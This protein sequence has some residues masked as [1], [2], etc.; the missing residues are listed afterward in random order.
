M[1]NYNLIRFYT[2]HIV[3]GPNFD[4][5]MMRNSYANVVQG[6]ESSY[7]VSHNIEEGDDCSYKN[8]SGKEKDNT[9]N[10]T[11]FLYNP[12][13]VDNNLCP[14]YIHNNDYPGLVLILKKLIGPDNYA[15]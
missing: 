11:E 14:L 15:P 12:L 3:W 13:F 2:S 5:V 10:V 4:I 9:K 7:T 8:L 6:V 1:F